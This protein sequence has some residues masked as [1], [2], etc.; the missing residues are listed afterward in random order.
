M[1]DMA[2]LI[3]LLFLWMHS[4]NKEQCW[5][6]QL[7]LCSLYRVLC[8][9]LRESRRGGLCGV[10]YS[11]RPCISPSSPVK[12]ENSLDCIPATVKT[13]CTFWHEQRMCF[14]QQIITHHFQ[15]W[16]DWSEDQLMWKKNIQNWAAH[17]NTA[18]ECETFISFSN[19]HIFHY[20]CSTLFNKV[21]VL[22]H[23]FYHLYL[24]PSSMWKW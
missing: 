4:T 17:V 22:Y 14:M 10:A 2:F 6:T 24:P 8:I 23:S 7:F 16:S 20:Y 9:H 18:I 1:V 5:S 13:G 11:V 21:S 3:M 12:N 19:R 15:S